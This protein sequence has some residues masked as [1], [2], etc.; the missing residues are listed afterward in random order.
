MIQEVSA[1]ISYFGKIPSRADF[2]KTADNHQLMALLDRWAGESIEALSQNPDW[3]ALYDNTS[4]IHYAFVG[5]RRRLVVCGHILPSHDA[6]A[7]RFP[8]L[9][10]LRIE[11]NNP[12]EFI[13]CS[14]LALSHVWVGLSRS[15]KEIIAAEDAS[16]L[17][18]QLHAGHYQINTDPK[19]YAPSINEFMESQTIGS[20]SSL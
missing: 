19:I 6:S 7:R 14:P 9:S 12:L 8:F 10:A 4:E 18:Q 5:S 2:V 3:K 16:P 1:A 11:V 17:L 20:L 13:G 15:V